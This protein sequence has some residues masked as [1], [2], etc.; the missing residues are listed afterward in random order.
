MTADVSGF[1]RCDS[2]PT[3]AL[4]RKS[5]VYGLNGHR[6]YYIISLFEVTYESTIQVSR[7]FHALFTRTLENF[8]YFRL[9][10]ASVSPTREPMNPESS[11]EQRTG[12]SECRQSAGI[13]HEFT[14][15]PLAKHAYFSGSL[16]AEASSLWISSVCL[17]TLD[18]PQPNRETAH[19]GQ[20][21]KR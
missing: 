12:L 5:T 13:D 11:P 20:S 15:T 8:R 1:A 4:P 2:E 10:R 6:S 16:V 9:M 14:Q 3:D 19:C 7:N 17:I 21:P 18:F